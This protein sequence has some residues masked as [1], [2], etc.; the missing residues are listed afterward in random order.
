MDPDTSARSERLRSGGGREGTATLSGRLEFRSRIREV[1]VKESRFHSG[2]S[3][4]SSS[5]RRD[6]VGM[7][8]ERNSEKASPNNHRSTS[9]RIYRSE[10]VSENWI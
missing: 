4:S 8:S 7:T 6:A 5:F 9:K 2:S 3:P 10:L 1:G